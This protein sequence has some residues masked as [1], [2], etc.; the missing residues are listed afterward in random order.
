VQVTKGDIKEIMQNIN[1]NKIAGKM[2]IV[3]GIKYA[4]V[5]NR[6]TAQ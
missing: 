3:G 6:K 1:A 2:K 5:K 4:K